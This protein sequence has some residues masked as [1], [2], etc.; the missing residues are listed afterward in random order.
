MVN[1]RVKSMAARRKSVTESPLSSTPKKPKQHTCPIC[2]DEINH[3]TQD[4]IFC[5]GNC[6]SWIHSGCGGLS[7]PGLTLAMKIPSWNCPSCRLVLQSSEISE[8]KKSVAALSEELF[9]L[10]ESVVAK[11]DAADGVSSPNDMSSF[12]A[13]SATVL[14]SDSLNRSR[15][16]NVVVRGISEQPQGTS[17]SV[18]FR[19]DHNKVSDILSNIERESSHCSQMCDCF[20]LGKY[21]P[22]CRSARPILVTLS[23]TVDVSN[24]LSNCH[25]LPSYISIHPDQSP[26]QRKVCGI[27]LK[28]RRRLLDDGVDR[29]SIKISNSQ[30]YVS[31]RLAGRVRNGVFVPAHSLC[32]AAPQLTD[33]HVSNNAVNSNNAANSNYAVNSNNAVNASPWSDTVSASN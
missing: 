4:S 17:R 3:D 26:Q 9:A 2:L 30:I 18:R 15:K 12:D 32:N 13:P 28:E 25:S 5:E 29:S 27:F 20:Q 22:D 14:S 1:V 7:K 23:S 11:L 6:K 33:L 16:F 21:S 31:C 10:R 24:I 19:S 8:L